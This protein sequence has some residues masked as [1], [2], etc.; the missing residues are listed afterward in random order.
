[1]L[2]SGSMATRD[3]RE[4][5]QRTEY[6]SLQIIDHQRCNLFGFFLYD[7][8]TIMSIYSY[9]FGKFYAP[10][11]GFDAPNI[12]SRI[13]SNNPIES[14][15]EASFLIITSLSNGRYLNSYRKTNV[16]RVSQFKGE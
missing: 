8:T 14:Y 1:M 6:P 2:Q 7:L 10:A 16:Y 4:Q 13:R 12:G 3:H 5:M 11:A 9:L 15:G